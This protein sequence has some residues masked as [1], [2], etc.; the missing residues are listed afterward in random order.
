MVTIVYLDAQD[1]L[2][3]CLGQLFDEVCRATVVVLEN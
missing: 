1:Y 2:V 3:G